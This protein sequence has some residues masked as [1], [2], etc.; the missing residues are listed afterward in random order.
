MAKCEIKK[1]PNEHTYTLIFN[2]VT[3]DEISSI[4]TALMYL[5]TSNNK[6]LVQS[7]KDAWQALGM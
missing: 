2:G 4:Q 3:K 7:I 5:D 6:K 1:K